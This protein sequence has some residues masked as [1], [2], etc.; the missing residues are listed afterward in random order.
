MKSK[1]PDLHKTIL[2]DER[3][4]IRACPLTRDWEN[5]NH[6]IKPGCIKWKI[7][8]QNNKSPLTTNMGADSFPVD[9]HLEEEDDTP[10]LWSDSDP[11]SSDCSDNDK[12]DS[13]GTKNPTKVKYL[14]F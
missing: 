3:C 7:I 12:D 13:K 9:E 4:Q 2:P 1:Y 14:S 8:E 11:G 5:I 10:P 6:A